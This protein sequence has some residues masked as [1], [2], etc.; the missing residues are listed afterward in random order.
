MSTM[1]VERHRSMSRGRGLLVGA[2]CGFMM[3]FATVIFC[4]GIYTFSPI[5][6][7]FAFQVI[8]VERVGETDTLFEEVEVEP[9]VVVQNASAPSEV[10]VDAG[11]L[12]SGTLNSTSRDF[13][14]QTGTT[15][16]G[17]Q[18][19]TVSF[20]ESE[21]LE[22]CREYSDV[23]RG[24]DNRLRDVAIDLRP[25]GA[26]VYA[27]AQFE[28]F[29]RTEWRRVGAVMRLDSSRTRLD[30]IGVDVAGTVYDAATLPG[31]LAA[32][33]GR[34]I[35]ELEQQGNEALQQLS[36]STGSQN[37]RLQRVSID[38]TSLTL[39]LQ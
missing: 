37:Y 25:G 19:A 27:N 9:T 20:T 7:P 38:D 15:V 12:G 11:R 2:G 22:L 28:L 5:L 31:E 8:G 26:V 3:L 23:C 4:A 35:D 14:V 13:S 16:E 32:S 10:R 18:V 1:R 24:Q 30:V 39:I 36:L 21:L 17:T 6:T 29:G 34:A 33:V